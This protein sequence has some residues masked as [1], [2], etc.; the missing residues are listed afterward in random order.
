M[1][2]ISP[3]LEFGPFWDS[4]WLTDCGKSDVQVQECRFLLLPFWSPSLKVVQF[5]P[6]ED[7]RPCEGEVKCPSWHLQ[8]T[9]ENGPPSCHSQFQAVPPAE[10]SR[11]RDLRGPGRIIS[12]PTYRIKGI[13]QL[14]FQATKFWGWLL[15]SNTYII[16]SFER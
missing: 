16:W 1:E 14:W 10:C 4:V 2:S 8:G 3:S 6:L 7:K 15:G 5:N 12:H 13:N 11:M 9:G